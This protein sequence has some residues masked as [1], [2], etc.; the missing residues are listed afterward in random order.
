MVTL[1]VGIFSGPISNPFHFYQ[2]VSPSFS[3]I[4][5]WSLSP[6]FEP[7]K[8]NT[9]MPLVLFWR[10]H[11]K[12]V[13]SFWFCGFHL[14]FICPTCRGKQMNTFFERSLFVCLI[15]VFLLIFRGPDKESPESSS[16]FTFFSKWYT[17]FNVEPRIISLEIFGLN[18][19]LF[20]ILWRGLFYPNQIGFVIL[21]LCYV[22]Y[23]AV[24]FF[25]SI[26]FSTALHMLPLRP[27]T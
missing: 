15:V 3:S 25:S 11:Y 4:R 8:E 23:D 21:V 13:L 2:L 26:A 27:R 24:H 18:S 14:P 16:R 17:L 6:W 1:R 7:W 22:Q 5:E 10:T 9:L 12:A 19:F 20:G